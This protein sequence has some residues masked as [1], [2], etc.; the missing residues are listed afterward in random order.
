ML[1]ALRPMMPPN[2]QVL[3][4]ILLRILEKWI[5]EGVN[6]ANCK[7]FFQVFYRT[8]SGVLCCIH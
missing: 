3:N 7:N 4:P 1:V 6:I 5:M 2:F 8:V